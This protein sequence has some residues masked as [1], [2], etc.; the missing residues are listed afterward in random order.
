MTQKQELKSNNLLYLK[1][2][3]QR[4]NRIFRLHIDHVLIISDSFSN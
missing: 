2:K 4:R 3:V 1:K